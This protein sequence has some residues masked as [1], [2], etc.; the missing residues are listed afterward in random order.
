MTPE[1]SVVIPT[2]TGREESLERCREAYR[3]TLRGIPAEIIV[4]R[5][6]PTCSEGANDGVAKARGTYVHNTADDLEP[7]AGWY[8]AGRACLDGGAIPSAYLLLPDGVSTDGAV[9]EDGEEA[10]MAPIPL[11]RREDWVDWPPIH[12]GSD[13]FW[14]AAMRQRGCQI[15]WCHGFRFTHHRTQDRAR[16]RMEGRYMDDM[17]ACRAG[18]IERGAWE[19]SDHRFFEGLPE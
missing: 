1:I 17:K 9:G 10:A 18:L 7:H 5:N 14:S 3:E 16:V 2:V 12:Y 15:R 8:E 4:V 11:I 6:R 19:F 13:V